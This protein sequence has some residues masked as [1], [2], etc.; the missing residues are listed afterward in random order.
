LQP[1]AVESA[2]GIIMDGILPPQALSSSLQQTLQ[3]FGFEGQLIAALNQ[4]KLPTS[5][6]IMAQVLGADKNG[7]MVVKAGSNELTLSNPLLIAKGATLTLKLDVISG[8]ITAELLSVDGKLPAS[9]PQNPEF[10]PQPQPDA[11]GAL[12]LKVISLVP[13]A[14]AKEAPIQAA[15]IKDMVNLSSGTATLKTLFIAPT[16]EIMQ[17]V[18]AALA[19][20]KKP[21]QLPE[22]LRPGQQAEAK[23]VATTAPK[24]PSPAPNQN[25]SPNQPQIDTSNK[26]LKAQDFMKDFTPQIKAMPN[27]NLQLN[28]MVLDTNNNNEVMVETKLGLIMLETDNPK[29]TKGTEVALELTK[30]LKAPA[31][32]QENSKNTLHEISK[33]W[34]GLK[35]LVADN[36]ESLQKLAGTNDYFAK[37]LAAFFEAV[38][39]SDIDG[40]LGKELMDKLDDLSRSQLVSKLTAEFGTLKNLFND[41]TSQW[42]TFAFPVFD[43]H[44]LQSAY[45]HIKNFKEQEAAAKDAGVR[46]MVELET[47]YYGQMQ[48]DGFVR[49]TVPAKSFDLIIRTTQKVDDE[50]KQGIN[51]IFNNARE[52]TGIKGSIEFAVT[53]EFMYSPWKDALAKKMQHDSWTG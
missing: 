52:V 49:K 44:D 9:Q 50:T 1:A 42:Q 5:T 36:K 22:D 2:K 16:P 37:K 28:G 17:G 45:L 39:K 33:N 38:Q 35:D 6:N 30:F 18:R 15:P 13:Q 29:L 26:V 24:A 12:P 23:V 34:P 27:G 46:F 48:L 19:E 20:V 40:W 11:R 10:T 7:N 14:A 31:P 8:N 53:R 4:S 47:S 43:G 3:Q 51:E 32:E 25:Q 21:M 41:Q